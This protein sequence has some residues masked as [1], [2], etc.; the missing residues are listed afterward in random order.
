V[1]HKFEFKKRKN[2]DNWLRKKILP[3]YK[4]L[5]NLGLKKG[6]IIAD[7]GCGIG[8]FSFPASKIVGPEGMVYAMDISTEMLNEIDKK[9]KKNNATNIKTIKVYEGNLLIEN[10]LVNF[11]F[12]CNVLHEVDD[13]NSAINEMRR[14]LIPSG[15]IAIIEWKKVKS[16]FGPPESHRLDT[17]ILIKKFK[18]VNF[19][20]ITKLEISKYLYAIEGYKNNF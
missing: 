3:P 8:Y 18:D 13:L 20:K 16:L 12:A 19:K 14:I 10:S 7:I 15:K 4:T 11:A 6:D 2:L 17:D 5:I 1:A 9:I